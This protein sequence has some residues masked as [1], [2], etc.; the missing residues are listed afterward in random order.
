MSIVGQFPGGANT[1]DATATA[2]D[3]AAGKTAYVKGAKVT[4]TAQPH[5]PYYDSRTGI[6]WTSTRP[7]M[8]VDPNDNYVIIV[9]YSSGSNEYGSVY[10][11]YK[12]VLSAVAGPTN[13][14]AAVSYANGV[15]TCASGY[16]TNAPAI[17]RVYR[18][19]LGN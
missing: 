10:T 5:L 18:G 3:I 16:G 7:T 15:L 6:S 1:Q 19:K 12:G 14:Y 17:T 8:P 13:D 11:L 2:G 9:K 4:G